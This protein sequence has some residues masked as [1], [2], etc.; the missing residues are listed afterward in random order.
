[1]LPQLCQGLSKQVGAFGPK[2][3][4][5]KKPVRI[6]R[7]QNAI[8]LV[9]AHFRKRKQGV[10]R[11]FQ[12]DAPPGRESF[13][14]GKLPLRPGTEGIGQI[15]AVGQAFPKGQNTGQGRGGFRIARIVG[16]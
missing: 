6:E 15:R 8:A 10:G 16:D 5:A 14:A 1:M 2:Q 4:C 3:G 9:I 13:L 7:H 12:I 11:A